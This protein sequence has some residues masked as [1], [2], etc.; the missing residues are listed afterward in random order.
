MHHRSEA[1]M[2]PTPDFSKLVPGFDFLQGLVR[3][4]GAALP[5][6]NEWIAPTLDPQ[7]LEKR[8]EQLKAVQFWLEQNARFVAASIQALEVQRMTLATLRSMNVPMADLRD[9][10]SARVTEPLAGATAPTHAPPPA[11]VAEPAAARQSAAP[12]P[13]RSRKPAESA[14]AA[15]A[16]A[17]AGARMVDPM[18]WWGALTEQFG[19][20][21]TAALKDSA[22]AA[23]APPPKPRAARARR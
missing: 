19:Q 17:E 5:G 20:L 15:P 21:A 10:F 8:I 13:K 14:A 23:P 9:A 12:K 7:Q 11:P 6:M 2:S 4:A 1:A 22:A 3:D 18:K 16:A